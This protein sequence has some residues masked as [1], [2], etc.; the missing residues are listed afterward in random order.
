VPAVFFTQLGILLS[1][2]SLGHGI[3]PIGFPSQPYLLLFNGSGE[4][5]GKSYGFSKITS[6]A[7]T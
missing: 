2:F 1:V 3:L 7:K 5:I 6:L 4:Q